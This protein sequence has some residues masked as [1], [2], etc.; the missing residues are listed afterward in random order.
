MC[1][2]LRLVL[3]AHVQTAFCQQQHP[4]SCCV[5]LVQYLCLLD[6]ICRCVARNSRFRYGSPSMCVFAWQGREHRC[7]ILCIGQWQNRVPSA[8]A[9]LGV[10]S[11]PFIHNVLGQARHCVLR[12]SYAGHYFCSFR[13]SFKLNIC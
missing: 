3:Q 12:T 2:T 8:V 5:V 1:G 9:C 6:V 10:C 7:R 4:S 13:K 11:L